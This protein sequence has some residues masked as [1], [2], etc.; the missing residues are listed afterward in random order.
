MPSTLQTLSNAY[1][2]VTRPGVRAIRTSPGVT[3]R[4]LKTLSPEQ[5]GSVD[6]KREVGEAL[7]RES[8][9]WEYRTLNAVLRRM[10]MYEWLLQAPSMRPYMK[11]NLSYGTSWAPTSWHG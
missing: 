1:L 5:T 7:E 4:R 9:A 8:E 3:S 10:E 6:W 11:K 2:A